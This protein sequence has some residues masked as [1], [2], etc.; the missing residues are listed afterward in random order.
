MSY[1]I[2]LPVF[3]GPFDLLFHLIEQEEI[4]IWDIP[5]ARITGQY[6][7]YLC[8][9]TELDLDVAGEFLVMAATLLAIKARL[10]LPAPPCEDEEATDGMAEPDP[11]LTLVARLLEYRRFK[12]AGQTLRQLAAGR[13]RL[14]PRGFS[15]IAGRV[16]PLFTRPVGD[17]TVPDLAAAMQTVLAAYR[18]PAPADVLPR[19]QVS[20]ADRVTELRKILSKRQ[21]VAFRD[22]LPPHPSRYDIV[23]SFLALLELVRLDVCAAVQQGLFGP[24]ELTGLTGPPSGARVKLEEATSG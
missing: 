16:A 21:V 6:L 4:N 10:L 12:E 11:R 7:D 13:D 17:L 3:E 24:I 5:I 18:P 8:S 9:L 23:V 1:Q 19:R 2:R 15:R 22:I 20:V 14:F